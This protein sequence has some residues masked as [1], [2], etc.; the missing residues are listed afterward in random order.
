MDTDM[1]K[2]QGFTLVEMLVVITIIIVLLAVLAPALDRAIYQAELAVCGANQRGVATTTTTYAFDHRRYYP[3]RQGIETAD[4]TEP[5][6]IADHTPAWDDRPTL[7]PYMDLNRMLNDPTSQFVDK[8]DTPDSDAGPAPELG[9][10]EATGVGMR[11][12]IV[13]SDFYLWFGFAYWQDDGTGNITRFGGMRKIGDRLLW[14]DDDGQ[15]QHH[16]LLA[17]DMDVIGVTA[18]NQHGSHPDIEGQMRNSVRHDTYVY[19]HWRMDS[20]RRPPLELNFAY[21]DGSVR[22]VNGVLYDDPRMRPIPHFSDFRNLLATQYA[23]VPGG[24]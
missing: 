24:D 14:K 7:T 6:R 12:A 18:G 23:N 2:R 16:T 8:I 11:K 22:R 15:A 20:Y 5:H 17:S 9:L 21:A 4:S 13:F 1:N 10:G 19:S 3:L